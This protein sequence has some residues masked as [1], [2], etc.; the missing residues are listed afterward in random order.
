MNLLRL[1]FDNGG[2]GGSRLWIYPVP[3]RVKSEP[4]SVPLAFVIGGIILALFPVVV[5]LYSLARAG[6]ALS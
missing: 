4:D 1:F 5:A 3:V 2:F 6:L